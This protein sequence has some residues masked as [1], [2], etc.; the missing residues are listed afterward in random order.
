MT[1]RPII[2]S[3]PM[4]RALL[5]GR[6]T[7]TRR[8]IKDQPGGSGWFCDPDRDH[9][10]V[11]V[12]SEG[13]P[14]IPIGQ[15]YAVGDRLW[16]REAWRTGLAYDDLKPSDLGGEEY[17]FFEADGTRVNCHPADS[18]LGRYRNYRCMPRWASR[19]TLTV[20]D[21]R[22]QRVQDISGDDA[23]A[24]GILEAEMEDGD[25]CYS[26]THFSYD[27][28]YEH[29]RHYPEEAFR[30]LW[31]SLNAK[32]RF[33]WGENPWVAAYTFTAERRNIDQPGGAS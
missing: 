11:F 24:E 13:L 26:G 15:T 20:T 9:G 10:W 5:D 27:V 6:K 1:D 31:D 3:G 30:D 12:P 25:I 7:Q 16:V 21:V 18:D 14:R 17:V 23:L 4:V 28:P 8:A 22:V 32:R 33:G 29:L 19:L 2:F